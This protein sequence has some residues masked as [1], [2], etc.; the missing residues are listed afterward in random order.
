MAPVSELFGAGDT[1]RFLC[2]LLNA[3]DFLK[4][5]EL[6]KLAEKA[7]LSDVQLLIPQLCSKGILIGTASGYYISS[8]GI[9]TAVLL[10]AT[11]GDIPISEAL[12]QLELLYPHV[13]PYQ[14]VTQNV[15]A[16]FINHLSLRPDF[17]RLYICSPWIRLDDSSL[18]RFAAATHEADKKY[19]GAVQVSVITRPPEDGHEWSEQIRNTLRALHRLGAIISTQRKLHAKLYIRE[20]GPYGGLHSAI[21]GSE[22]LTA[23][24]NIELGI[25][26]DNNNEILGKLTLF[27]REIEEE[28]TEIF[29]R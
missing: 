3:H 26:I 27:F 12:R 25:R 21:F 29:R 19:P 22:N 15:T 6:V 9:R 2:E 4:E 5:D 24:Q 20:P 7:E 17:I 13:K 1:Y 14:L 10:R 23:A 28:A 16:E 18:R 11:N 8:F